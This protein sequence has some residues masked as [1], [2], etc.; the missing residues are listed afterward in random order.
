MEGT[1]TAPASRAHCE[2]GRRVRRLSAWAD[3]RLFIL[4]IAPGFV[5]LSAVIFYPAIYNLVASFTDAS[6]VYPSTSFVGIDN[7]SDTV[8][9]P[10]FWRAALMTLLWTSLS[11]AGQLM[12]GLLGAL[13]L[14]HVTAGR[15]ALRL[16]LVVPWAFP[17]IVLAFDWRFMLDPLYGVANHLLML[18]GLIDAPAA[19]LS[20]RA[21]ALPVLV[22]MNVWF[23]FPFMMVSLIAG[24]AAIP[25]EQY[26]AATV[27]GANFW[28]EFRFI[29]LPG[30][31][32]IMATLVILR[33]IWVF[34]NFEFVFLTTGG[35][36]VDATTT[37]PIYAFNIGWIGY[38]LGRMAA[39]AVLMMTLLSLILAIYFR[40]LRTAEAA[41]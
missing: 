21:T 24:L 14:E 35:G 26:E 10:A 8:A 22:L 15:A 19:W 6:L 11:V 40:V 18:L 38:D 23:G 7:Y 34:N 17:S 9:D 13:A 30:L 27:D 39:V 41:P 33:T 20:Q 31:A 5:C 37:L 16:A 12:V 32:R 36:P 2:I 29:T 4:F 28:Q 1:I 25:R 3:R